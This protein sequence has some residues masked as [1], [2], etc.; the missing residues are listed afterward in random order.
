MS[1]KTILVHLND[2][3]RAE[4]VLEPAAQLATRYN[5]HLI[6]LHVYASVPASPIPL[7]STALGSIVAADRK[8]SEAIAETFKRMTTNK[9]FVA[10]WQLQ[11]VPHV[12]LASLVMER[13][14]AADLLVAGQTDPD[15]DLSPLL[16]FPERLAL[17]SG[18]PVLVIPYAGRFS[19][20][21]RRVVIAW[22]AGREATRAAF[23][24][25]PLLQDAES[26]HILEIKERADAESTPGSDT[27]IAAALAR[28]GVKPVV[29][30]SIASDISVGDEILSR[31]SD[32]DADL[33]VMGA[34]GHSRFRE[35]VFGGAT[36]HIARHMTLPTL[37]SH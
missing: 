8:N 7:A 6:G 29:R 35:L 3:R 14:R 21:G 34:Y 5:S 25:L 16:D 22:K 37:F 24:A 19:R 2:S 1:Y 32:L 33:L 13:G 36:R 18:R 9:E 31:V 12:D 28:H 11:K 15:W 27:S 20:I 26:V 30:T 4:A 17:E 10:E 23:D